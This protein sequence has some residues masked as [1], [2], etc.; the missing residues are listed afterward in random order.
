MID[1]PNRATAPPT[2]RIG[3]WR[4][5]LIA[6]GWLMVI[7]YG[8]V[9]PLRFDPAAHRHAMHD[10]LTS[11]AWVRY[12]DR[13]VSRLGVPAWASDFALNAVLYFPLGMF[14][15]L[16]LEASR[17]RRQRRQVVPVT[18]AGLA[19]CWLLESAQHLTL[20]RVASLQDVLFN[21]FGCSI[22]AAVAPRTRD[23][24]RRAI[25][26]AY[27]AVSY[28]VHQLRQ[29]LRRT[30]QRRMIRGALVLVTAAAWVAF[31][32]M[33]GPTVMRG[34][35]L[36]AMPFA[37]QF[38]KPYDEAVL[39][40]LGIMLPYAL[41]TWLASAGGPAGMRGRTGR[42]AAVAAVV[43]GATLMGTM[44]ELAAFVRRGVTMDVTEPL[45]A[46]VAAGL[47][48]AIRPLVDRVIRRCSR[49]RSP[50][51]VAVDRRRVPFSYV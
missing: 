42:I 14:G 39:L 4:Y 44:H 26:L 36:Q 33:L 21:T 12:D 48:L 45:L 38:A 20:D 40:V 10:V 22:G 49:R 1:G 16:M 43:M 25:F 19:I 35:A 2:P 11:P 23:G 8:S 34:Q 17:G 3:P 30:Q 5:G 24:L 18:L 28:P 47:A 6:A 31:G 7:A 50:A 15:R 41:W 32:A 51:P 46:A 37:D 29:W 9:T 13:G 27:C